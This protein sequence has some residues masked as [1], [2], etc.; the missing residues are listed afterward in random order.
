[1]GRV[2]VQVIN[3]VR[4]YG[5]KAVSWVKN[6]AGRII[7]WA[8]RGFSIPDIVQNVKDILGIK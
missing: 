5:G 7:D 1:M 6:N 2:V 8:G 4:K 3:A